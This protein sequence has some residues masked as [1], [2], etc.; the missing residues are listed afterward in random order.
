MFAIAVVFLIWFYF[1]V[2][3]PEW[4]SRE[5]RLAGR[6]EPGTPTYLAQAEDELVSIWYSATSGRGDRTESVGGGAVV[7]IG[8]ASRRGSGEGSVGGSA[9]V[10]SRQPTYHSLASG[11]GSRQASEGGYYY[12]AG[13]EG[14]GP[15]TGGTAASSFY[16]ADS[17]TAGQP[18]LGG[19]QQ[20]P[21]RT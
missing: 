18:Q 5:R 15:T 2:Y 6:E 10:A 12:S 21:G 17:G 3:R 11:Q 8:L 16:S 14:G 1:C 13:S 9:A 7:A 19:R 20:R 4:K